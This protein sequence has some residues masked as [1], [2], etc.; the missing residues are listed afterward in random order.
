MFQQLVTWSAAMHHAAATGAHEGVY[1]LAEA[2]AISEHGE[3]NIVNNVTLKMDELKWIDSASIH[4]H[5]HHLD[6]LK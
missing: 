3:L 6:V 5:I 1:E 4:I 2:K